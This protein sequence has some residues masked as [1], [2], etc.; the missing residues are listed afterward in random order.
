MPCERDLRMKIVQIGAML[1]ER[2]LI[3]ATEGNVSVRMDDGRILA[4]PTG[5]R[6]HQLNPTDL[7]LLDLDGAHLSGSPPSSEI[8]MHLGLY[9]ELPDCGAIVH[10]HP[11]HATAFAAARRALPHPVLAEAESFLGP[12]ALVPYAR[13]GTVEVAASLGPFMSI[14]RAF[15]LSNHGATTIGASLDEAYDRMEIL[16]R[17]ARV[18]WLSEALG[19]AHTIELYSNGFTEEGQS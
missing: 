9:R 6:K 16:E 18:A 12:V 1:W 8:R 11:P 15:L 2:G 19:G 13:A 7:P 10:A 17:V 4:T 3:G 14:H 5:V